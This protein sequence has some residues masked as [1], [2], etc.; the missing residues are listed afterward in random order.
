MTPRQYEDLRDVQQRAITRLYES[1]GVQAVMPMGSGKTVCALTAAS[2]MLQDGAIRAGVVAAPPRVAA[3]TWSTEVAKWSHL[4]GLRL[5]LLIGTPKQRAAKLRQPADV[6]VVSLENLPWLIKE[7]RKLGDDHPAWDLL[8]I[9]ELS[10]MKSPRGARAKALNRN[11]ERF[12]NIWGL[13]GTPKPNSWEDQ[14]MP[15]QLVSRGWAWGTGFDEWRRDH[16]RQ[17]D[18]QGHEWKPHDFMLPAIRKVVD[19]YTFT[20]DPAEAAEVPFTS[21]DEHDV[22]VDLCPA[23]LRDLESLEKELMVEL[24]R[25]GTDLRVALEEE[26]DDLVVA[27]AKAQATGKMEQVL[28]GFLYRDAKTV[29][30]YRR[31]KLEALEDMLHAADAEPVL[32]A[33]HFKED[34]ENLRDLLGPSLPYLGQ[35]VSNKRTDDLVEAWG[36]GEVSRLALHPASAGHGLDG[37]QDGGRRFIWYAPTWSPELYLQAIKRLARSGQKLPVFSHRIRARHWLED[38]RISRVEHKIK[39]EIDFINSLERV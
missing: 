4:T 27:L 22:V 36:R 12:K 28:Q 13:T 5:Q 31:A 11:V 34:L 15:V 35:G 38:M 16:F 25:E 33:Y 37:L 20:V 7:L 32:I 18:H 3:R 30:T 14:W 1:Q 23:A 9:D 17:M 10:R 6:Y 29:Q 19:K 39:E 8:I 21:G 26:D 2:E 24:G